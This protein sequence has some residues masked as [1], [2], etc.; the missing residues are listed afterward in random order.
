VRYSIGATIYHDSVWMRK[1]DGKW[2]PAWNQY[3]SEY[4]DDPF[5]DQKPDEAK[6]LIKRVSD[7]EKQAPKAWW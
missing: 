7:W 5:D 2:R 6:A 3:L 4:A 1:V